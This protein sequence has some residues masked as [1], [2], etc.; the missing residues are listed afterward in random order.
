MFEFECSYPCSFD[1]C[2]ISWSQALVPLDPHVLRRKE[3]AFVTAMLRCKQRQPIFANQ[4]FVVPALLMNVVSCNL[5]VRQ[6]GF[7][8]PEE[9]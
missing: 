3:V 8:L 2:A 1:H 7:T 5:I 6:T 4:V 9:Q